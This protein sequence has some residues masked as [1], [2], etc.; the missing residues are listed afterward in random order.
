MISKRI[1]K[2]IFFN[3][4]GQIVLHCDVQ[5]HL[6]TNIPHTNTQNTQNICRFGSLLTVTYRSL[7]KCQLAKHLEKPLLTFRRP[8]T[9]LL[10]KN[11]LVLI[12]PVIASTL[13]WSLID[14]LFCSMVKVDQI[15]PNLFLQNIG[16]LKPIKQQRSGLRSLTTILCYKLSK[17]TNLDLNYSAVVYSITFN[18]K[19]NFIEKLIYTLKFCNSFK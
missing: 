15:T 14:R 1:C 10:F 16:R 2:C 19:L 8:N 4:Y 6:Q 18:R 7:P 3:F 11:K 5:I 12:S 9:C 17:C 13:G